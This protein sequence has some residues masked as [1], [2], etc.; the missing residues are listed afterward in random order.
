MSGNVED[1]VHFAAYTS[2]MDRDDGLRPGRDLT[3]EQGFVQV[4]G[5]RPNVQEDRP[6]PAQDKSVDRRDKR[7][8]GNDHFVA[9]LDV[10]QDGH[11]IQG[12][13]ARGS[14][15]HFRDAERFFEELAAL[16]G[17]QPIPGYFAGGDCLRNIFYLVAHQGGE[18]EI[19]GAGG[20]I[21][22][23][24]PDDVFQSFWAGHE[25]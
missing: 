24:L 18:V 5:I 23:R 6:R 19:N 22:H 14:Q 11:H 13:G 3:L 1:G 8:G 7:K 16:F 2:V 25:Q 15:Q 20:I 10:Q 9:R 4:K 21:R 17:K 12:V